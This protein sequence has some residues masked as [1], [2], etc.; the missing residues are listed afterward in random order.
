MVK[1]AMVKR[2][3]LRGHDPKIGPKLVQLGKSQHR[4]LAL[5][6]SVKLLLPLLLPRSCS[7]Q[8]ILPTQPLY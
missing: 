8:Q 5:I 3:M 4:I 2:T 1:L 7:A 6:W